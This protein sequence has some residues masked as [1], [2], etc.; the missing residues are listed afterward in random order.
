MTVAKLFW[1]V[2][3]ADCY[4]LPQDEKDRLFLK[5]FDSYHEALTFSKQYAHSAIHLTKRQPVYKHHDD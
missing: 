1:G 4:K 3:A 5:S 2:F